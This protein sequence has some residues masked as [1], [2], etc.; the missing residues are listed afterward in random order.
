MG[1]LLR[2]PVSLRYA[3][4][5]TDIWEGYP[6]FS[7]FLLRGCLSLRGIGLRGIMGIRTVSRKFGRVVMG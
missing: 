2:W 4:G 6:F 3:T 1:N 7:S 5:I